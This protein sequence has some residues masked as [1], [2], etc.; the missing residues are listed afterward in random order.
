MPIHLEGEAPGADEGGVVDQPLHVLQVEVLP[1]EMPSE[2]VLDISE[3][4]IGD[5]RRVGD[6]AM[7]DGV[8][9]LDDPER[10]VVTV[11][12]PQLEVPEPEETVVSDQEAEL[13]GA[14]GEELGDEAA[15][16]AAAEAGDEES[17]G[18]QEQ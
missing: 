4:Q 5:V 11:T 17:G 6:I 2:F 1:L 7:P 14:A 10:A 9:V 3:L 12:V 15:A 18:G 16:E 8:T 13:V